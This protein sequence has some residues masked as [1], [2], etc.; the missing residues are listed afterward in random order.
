MKFENTEIFN[1]EG[2]FRGLRNP[3]ES[4]DKSDSIVLNDRQYN[5]FRIG[6]ND[7]NLAQ[8][9]LKAGTDNSIN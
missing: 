3:L 8:R 9:M 1:F 2:S 4:W 7:L 5:N 6:K